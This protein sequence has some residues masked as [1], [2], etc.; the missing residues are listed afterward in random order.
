MDYYAHSIG[1]TPKEHW[2]TL[3]D[4]LDAVA[5]L[6]GVFAERFSSQNVAAVIGRLHDIG[7]YTR[8]FQRR[9]EGAS[10]HVDHST[11]GGQQ[12]VKTMGEGMGRLLAYAIMG[13][14]GGL[15][16]GIGPDDTNLTQRLKK[17]LPALELPQNLVLKEVSI[18]LKLKS[19]IQGFQVSFWVRM[20]FSCLVDADYLDTERFLSSS[21]YLLRQGYPSLTE[22]SCRLQRHLMELSAKVKPTRINQLRAEILSH[23]N[24]AAEE[25]LGFFSL[26]VPTGGGKT[27]SSFSFACK[28]AVCHSLQRVI[29]VI[30]YT[31]IIEQ[32]AEVF[33][34]AVG[35]DAVLEHHS[36][37]SPDKEELRNDLAAENWDAPL[38]VTTSVQFF[39]SL[40]HNRPSRCRKLHNIAGSVVILDEAQMLPPD[41]LLPCLEALRELVTNY[42]CSVVLCTATQ[43]AL[44][45][46]LD[47]PRGLDDVL[48]IVPDTEK[49]F[50]ELKRVN[51]NRLERVSA[52]GLS[53]LLV[54]HEK[55][56]CVVNTRKEAANLFARLN[57]H[58][59]TYHL[60]AAMCP[61]HRSVVLAEIKNRLVHPESACRVVSTQLI[62]A[63]VD[64]DFP[65]VYRALSGVDSIAQAAGRCNREGKLG[66][67]GEVFIFEPE[68]APP[69]GHLRQAAEAACG[70]LRHRDDILQPE[71]VFEYFSLLYWQE[72]KELDAGRILERFE[73]GKG[74]CLF[75]FRQVADEFSFIKDGGASV[76]IPWGDAGR[77]LIEELRTSEP[78]RQLARQLQRFTVQV[79]PREF[80]ALDGHGAL[81]HLHERF[82]VLQFPEF[83]SNNT[84]LNPGGEGLSDPESF[85]V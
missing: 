83:Y 48:E 50:R 28:H 60:S 52:E 80:Q 77:R 2:Q 34:E 68:K 53:E 24:Q 56:L 66:K 17:V 22:I 4:H 78:N 3:E 43:P 38:V 12:A 63:G 39:E 58:E 35:D 42:G 15:P 84:G 46:T 59:G 19:G 49:Y 9:L 13:H 27:L 57:C 40:F 8:E 30:P 76:I 45:K 69:A 79:R 25:R 47:F 33:R 36:N 82:D 7:K 73:D 67:P 11:V 65:V 29:Y 31:S 5:R 85:I 32:N 51:I 20:L 14:H 75:P 1:D 6:A 54:E 64:I 81:L 16:D 70:V 44:E 37:F 23:C 62:E 61:A 72:G 26:T 21:K 71:A 74:Q 41:Y 10:E 18:P 55:V